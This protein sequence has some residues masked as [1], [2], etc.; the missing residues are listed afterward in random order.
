[1]NTFLSTRP[2]GERS[3]GARYPKPELILRPC[4]IAAGPTPSAAS[5]GWAISASKKVDDISRH[6]SRHDLKHEPKPGSNPDA[7]HPPSQKEEGTIEL[8][9]DQKQ[10]GKP[11]P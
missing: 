6:E 2:E 11:K 8:G 9:S 10:G 4:M 1:M 7:Q 5:T 3:K